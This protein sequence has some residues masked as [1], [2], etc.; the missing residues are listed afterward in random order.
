MSYSVRGKTCGYDN[1]AV[2]EATG[3][4]RTITGDTGLAEIYPSGYGDSTIANQ[5]HI[6]NI[7][8]GSNDTDV[9]HEHLT[10]VAETP[11][12]EALATSDHPG[13]TS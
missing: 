5:A 12:D 3:K 6:T 2:G 7:A 11:T 8:A 10:V 1:I 9:S 4:E 13:F